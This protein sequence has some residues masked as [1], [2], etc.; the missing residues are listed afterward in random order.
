[1]TGMDELIAFLAA[2]LAEDWG[3]AH[4]RELES[5]LVTSRGTRA[6]DAGRQLLAYYGVDHDW[7]PALAFAIELRAAEYSDHPDYRQEWKP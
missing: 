4:D 3:A 2:R 6:A 1:M 7:D 5:G